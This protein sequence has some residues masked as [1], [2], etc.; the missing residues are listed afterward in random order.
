MM[1]K[2][3][4]L[5]HSTGECIWKGRTHRYVYR[6]TRTGDV[7][8]H[9]KQLNKSNKTRL[10]I[11]KISFPATAGWRNYPHD[12]YNIWIKNAGNKPYKNELTLELLTRDYD[13]IIFKHCYP[14][15][16]IMEDTGKPDIDSQEKRLENY[17]LQY[18]ALKS[19]MHEFPDKKFI[20][21]TPAVQVKSRI[22]EDE[23]LRAREFHRWILEEW[24]EKKDNIFIWDFYSYETEGGLY[25]KE[26]YSGDADESHPGV[27]FSAQLAPLF[28]K[29]VYDV[30][31]GAIA[32]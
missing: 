25:F 27:E 11:S 15:S 12:Y 31:T 13:V 22:T 26:E 2:I 8:R 28:A 21:W 5:H 19:K 23:A 18:N 14:A 10:S 30:A 1:E 4:F 6:L 20:V 3:V 17:K 7:Q 24:D 32:E 9:F 29:F 16:N